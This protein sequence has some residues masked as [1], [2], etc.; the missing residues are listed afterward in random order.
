MQGRRDPTATSAKAKEYSAS[1][2]EGRMESRRVM[3]QEVW[4]RI[5]E[6]IAKLYLAYAD[7]GRR[8]RVEQPAGGVRY[9]VFEQSKFLKKDKEGNL[10]YE[11][12]FIFTVD[13]A[14]SIGES[15]E[16][17][18]Q[19]INRSFG[20]GTLGNPQDINT[21]ILYWGLMEEQ[22]YPGAGRIKKK[23][24]ELRDMQAQ[25]QQPT[26]PT[27]PTA[28]PAAGMVPGGAPMM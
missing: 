16:A 27:A 19:E 1:K 6:M 13:D 5:Y 25:A 28:D 9:D 11:D 17:M 18:W 21:L 12:G 26:V 2:A 7:E 3:K 24:E 15:R 20:A 10:Y 4:A 14:T 8:L 23:M 22:S